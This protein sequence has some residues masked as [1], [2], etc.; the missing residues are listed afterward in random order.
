MGG[1]NLVSEIKPL[2]SC[3][4]AGFAAACV[5]WAVDSAAQ[6]FVANAAKHNGNIDARKIPPNG[7]LIIA[8]PIRYI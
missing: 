5:D 8:A 4:G 7:S 6:L 3:P 1:A 2:S